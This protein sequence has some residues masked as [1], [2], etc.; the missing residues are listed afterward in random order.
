MLSAQ[1]LL[2]ARTR[3][4][5]I[6][7]LLAFLAPLLTRL[8]IG[9]AF[10]VTGSGKIA[11]LENVV[12]FFT[13]LGI[14]WPEANAL[15]I[16]RLEYWGG[17]L[18]VAGLATRLVAAGLASTMVV[19]LLTAERQNFL[20]AFYRTGESGLTDVVPFVYLIFLVWLVLT[21]PGALSLDGLLLRLLEKRAPGPQAEVVA[22]AA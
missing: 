5:G 2:R 11:N 17:L 22:Q 10:Y 4:L 8:V 14:P 3:A 13:D 15:F 19:A 1:T 18:L 21:G 16:S 6:L 20:D 12:A 7:G 9:Q